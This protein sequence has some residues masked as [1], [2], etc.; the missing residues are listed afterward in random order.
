MVKPELIEAGT[1]RG[2][3]WY[4]PK[5]RCKVLGVNPSPHM[6]PEGLRDWYYKLDSFVQKWHNGPSSNRR[7]GSKEY[8]VNDRFDCCILAFTG[9]GARK[10]HGPDDW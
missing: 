1:T 3:I 5:D 7:D 2:L 9:Y 6:S 4:T 8:M 10:P